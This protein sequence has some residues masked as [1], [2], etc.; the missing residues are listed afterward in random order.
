L[1]H[2]GSDSLAMLTALLDDI[3]KR[4]GLVEK[5][6]GVFYRKRKAFLHFHEDKA[7]LFMDIRDGTDW[8]RL[9]AAEHRQCLREIDRILQSPSAP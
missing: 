7:G 9:P 4:S 6:P 3:R 1:K 5:T 2:A 8:L